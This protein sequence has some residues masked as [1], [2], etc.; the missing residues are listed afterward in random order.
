VSPPLDPKG[1]EPHSLLGDLKRL[2]AACGDRQVIIITPGLRY[3]QAFS[4]L[5]H[6]YALHSPPHS[7]LQQ[8]QD[9][10]GPQEAPVLLFEQAEQSTFP[11]C[12]VVS[13]DDLLACQRGAST[14][15]TF[16]AAFSGSGAVQLL[17]HPHG[18]VP[19]R[20]LPGRRRRQ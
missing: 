19:G 3:T 12:V 2:L 7:G 11:K 5:L 16:A 6:A 13:A 10:G 20:H 14:P 4:C 17:L 15:E 8:H 9:A 1:G 18:P